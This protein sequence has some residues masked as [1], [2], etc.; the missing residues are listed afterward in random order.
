[1]S[2]DVLVSGAQRWRTISSDVLVGGAER[3]RRCQV[4]S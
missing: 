2:S 1:M 4:M 3:Y